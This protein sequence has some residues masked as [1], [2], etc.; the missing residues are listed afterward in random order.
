MKT[1]KDVI[2]AYL[3]ANNGNSLID[4]LIKIITEYVSWDILFNNLDKTKIVNIDTIIKILENVTNVTNV[5]INNLNS[6]EE[7]F[8]YNRIRNF[9]QGTSVESYVKL[10]EWLRYHFY[11]F[12]HLNADG[13]TIVDLMLSLDFNVDVI[14]EF[15]KIPD[16]NLTKYNK[17]LWIILHVKKSY[18]I[19]LGR[20]I[21]GLLGR[22]DYLQVD[23]ISNLLK[24]YGFPSAEDDIITVLE[25]IRIKYPK[26]LKEMIVGLAIPVDYKKMCRYISVNK[27]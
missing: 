19:S 11:N 7:T 23:L 10:I 2:T 16:F 12:N 27:C 24:E 25:L 15:L 9:R 8:M 3:E 18:K 26:K 20:I 14:I 5:N 17:W 1:G 4:E 21:Y 6:K 22:N 13:D